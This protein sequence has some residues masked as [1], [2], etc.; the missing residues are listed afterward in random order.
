MTAEAREHFDLVVVGGGPGGSTISSFVAMDGHRVLLLER[1]KFPRYQIGESLLPSTVHGICRLLGLS[2]PIAQAGFMRKHGGT[3]RWGRRPEPWTFAFREATALHGSGYAYQVE[4]SKFDSLLL[5]HARAKGVV[6]RE[7]STVRDVLDD[8]GRVAGVLYVDEAGQE[9]KIRATFVADA[10]G[11][12]GHLHSR[13]GE[14]IFSKFF[15]NVALFC[16]FENGKRLPPPNS[17]NILCAAFDEGWFWYI[18]LTDTL[19]S[20]GAVIA[21]EHAERL[22]DGHLPAML[23]FIESCPLIKDY[24]SS[25]RRVTDGP[26]G[27]FRVRKDYSYANAKFWAPGLVL[28]GDAACFIDPVFSSGVHLSTYS[29]LLAARSINSSLRGDASEAR[30]FDEFERRYRREYGLFYDFLISFYDMHQDESSYYWKARKVLSSEE[31]ANEAFVR[32]VGG[33]GS[34][35]SEFFQRR[36]GVGRAAESLVEAVERKLGAE[37]IQAAESGLRVRERSVE[38]G[39]IMAQASLGEERPA[40]APLF[41]GGLVPSRSG[42]RWA[43]PA[44]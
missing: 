28:I 12:T 5:D 29:A 1:E 34:A 18:P 21:R 17:G 23:S 13:A 43:E 39:Q 11:N 36:E 15:Q 6:V 42:L 22:K 30:C 37:A 9:H 27:Q 20:V 4:R 25:A 3:F 19:T 10:S 31:Q 8:G 24:L 2:E 38:S 33:G 7:R 35:A 40:E 16:Y 14:R 32:L 44:G 41:P 26:Y